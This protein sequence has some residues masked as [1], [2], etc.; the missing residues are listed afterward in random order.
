MDDAR[1]ELEDRARARRV[2]RALLE[3]RPAEHHLRRV[4]LVARRVALVVVGVGLARRVEGAVVDGAPR[5]QIHATAARAG[6]R[7]AP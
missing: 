1:P 4:A 5:A 3:Q 2:Q 6:S 7:T